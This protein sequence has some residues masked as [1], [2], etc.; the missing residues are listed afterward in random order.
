M[1]NE[2]FITM[3]NFATIKDSKSW[4]FIKLERLRGN[5]G[6]EISRILIRFKDGGV[7]NGRHA[8]RRSKYE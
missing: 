5:M 3:T 4:I 2:V 7:V 6:M 8:G 1:M